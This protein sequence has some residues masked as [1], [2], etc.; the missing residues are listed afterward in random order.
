M[1]GRQLM[2]CSMRYVIL[3]VQDIERSISFYKDLLGFPIR[4]EHG[5]YIE[6]DTGS[7]IL[8]IN[9]RENARNC[10]GLDV[11]NSTSCTQTFELAFVVD[12][13][14]STIEQLREMNVPILIEPIVKPWGQ[15][16]AYIADPDGHFI[17]ICS[18]LD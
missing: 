6:F 7:T 14:I 8:G 10:T 16:V 11:P 1:K 18:T 13:V 12:D 15:T 9:T 2:K 17:E 5:T 4:G 3:Y